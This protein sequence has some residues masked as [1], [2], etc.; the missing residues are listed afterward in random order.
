MSRSLV[1]YPTLS[2]EL[3]RQDI[4]GRELAERVGVH[5]GSISQIIRGRLRPSEDLRFRIADYLGVDESALF[6]LDPA[7]EALEGALSD[8][9]DRRTLQRIVEA[10]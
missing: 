9:S 3:A 1:W 4:T 8:V 5:P 2:A 10:L 7:V 6:V